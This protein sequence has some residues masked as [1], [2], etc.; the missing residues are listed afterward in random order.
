MVYRQKHPKHQATP[1]NMTLP[2][3]KIED[4]NV[5]ALGFGVMQMSMP[6]VI[7]LGEEERLK[8]CISFHLTIKT[9]PS[10]RPHRSSMQCLNKAARFGTPRISMVIMKILSGNGMLHIRLR[11]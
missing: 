8:V 2:T 6:K 5:S 3:R 9:N 11:E 10:L 1:L 7:A 4:A